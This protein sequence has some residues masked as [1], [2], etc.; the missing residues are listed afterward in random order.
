MRSYQ[1]GDDN[2]L[3]REREEIRKEGE[4]LKKKRKH[5][6]CFHTQSAAL[7]DSHPNLIKYELLMHVSS[8]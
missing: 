6:N 4:Y 8:S 1:I 7:V 5:D 3:T 2:Y